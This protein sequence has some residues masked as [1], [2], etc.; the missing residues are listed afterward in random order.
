MRRIEKI[1]NHWSAT[2]K[3]ADVAFIRQIHKQ[4]G[5][6]DIGYHRVILHPKSTE[7]RGKPAPTEWWH[8]VKKGRYLNDDLYLEQNEVGAHTLYYNSVS[9][10]VCTIGHPSYPLDPLQKQAVIMT[11]TILCNRYELILSQAL[12]VHRDF[13]A[14]QCPGDEI[15]KIIQSLKGRAV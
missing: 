1:I 9:V 14:T 4:K 2:D 12:G 8:L 13:N 5:W 7:F 10:G 6:R 3:Y 11:N 15:A